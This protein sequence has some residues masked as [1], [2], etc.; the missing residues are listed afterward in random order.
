MFGKKAMLA[1]LLFFFWLFIEKVSL[2]INLKE[3]LVDGFRI[4][5][6]NPDSE[7]MFVCSELE[8]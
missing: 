7:L 6:M 2:L 5:I 4:M 3:R 1:C 8:S